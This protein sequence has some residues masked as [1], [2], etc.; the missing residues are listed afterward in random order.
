MIERSDRFGSGSMPG[1]EPEPHA[2]MDARPDEYM[3]AKRT[4]QKLLITFAGPAMNLLLPVVA[5]WIAFWTV[6]N[7]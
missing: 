7:P 3:S 2:V 4:W 5:F 6:M 1:G